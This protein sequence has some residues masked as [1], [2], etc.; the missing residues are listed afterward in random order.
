MSFGAIVLTFIMIKIDQWV[1]QTFL[2]DVRF[3]Y[4]NQPDGARALLS[5]IA[6]SMITVAGVTFSM[7]LLTVSHASAQIG[8]RT[9]SGFMNDRGN[10][11]TLGTFIATFVYSILILRTIHASIESKQQEF[12][13][14]GFIPHL[15]I[16]MA[17][18]LAL[19][20]V[21]VLIYFIHHVP[22]MISTTATVARIGDD[23]I[24]KINSI[25]PENIGDPQSAKAQQI[26]L[27]YKQFQQNQ[28]ALYAK[29]N[30][31][32]RYADG[33]R[34]IEIAEKYHVIIELAAQPGQYLFPDLP[35]AYITDIP[36]ERWEKVS[37]QVRANLFWGTERSTEQDLFFPLDLLVEIA[38]RALSPGINDP[39]TAMEC[40]NHWVTGL[41]LLGKR[42]I[43]NRFRVDSTE[44]LRLVMPTISKQNYVD[45]FCDKMRQHV[46]V[47]TTTT[48]HMLE[49]LVLA[50]Q[51]CDDSTLKKQIQQQAMFLQKAALLQIEDP[52]DKEIV[53]QASQCLTNNHAADDHET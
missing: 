44:H 16:F 39:H 13:V 19:L 37:K 2:Q 50:H 26:Q 29:E 48:V 32:M 22:N 3:L 12:A 18:V 53:E 1:G 21:S 34:L 7:T 4:F 8:P 20:S 11:I 47:D 17:I 28:K 36:E 14:D 10:Q 40:I 51:V 9:L 52:R 35:L 23:L 30:G 27:A 38:A 6:G 49:K 41:I 42:S 15:S 46:C 5:T 25:F 31:F 43:P 24:R 33:D 45:R